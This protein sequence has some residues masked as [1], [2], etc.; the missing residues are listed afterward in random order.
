MVT[1]LIV[2]DEPELLH[3][4]EAILV[5]EGHNVLKAANGAEALNS[6]WL[7]NPDIIVTDIMMPGMDGITLLRALKAQ[8]LLARIPVILTTAINVPKD[9]PGQGFLRKPF[10]AAALLELI[11]R[12]AP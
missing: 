4:L 1:V 7:H 9:L 10:S 2:E 5:L 12:L 3:V 11:N 8:P 6:V